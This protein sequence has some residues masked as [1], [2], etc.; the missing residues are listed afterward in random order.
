LDNSI[1]KRVIILPGKYIQG[2]GVLAGIYDYISILGKKPVFIWTKSAR[3]VLSPVILPVLKKNNLDFFEVLFSG[4]CTRQEAARISGEAAINGADTVIGAG[5]G[6]VIDIAKAVAA[7]NNAPCM[8]IPTVP[9]SDA[10]ASSYTVW[11]NEEGEFD[12]SNGWKFNPDIVI[13]DTEILVKAPKRFFIAGIG[14]ALA[15]WY[16]AAAV[17]SSG[18]E[19][20]AG[21]THTLTAVNSAKLCLDILFEYGKAA[22]ESVEKKAVSAAFENVIEAVIFL[23]GIGWENCGVATAHAIAMSI[24]S[25]FKGGHKFLHGECVAFGLLCQLCLEKESK[26]DELK[27][28][29]GFMA[30]MELPLSFNDLGIKDVSFKKIKELARETVLNQESV[31]NHNF[32]VTAKKLA[33]AIF[34][35]NEIGLKRK[36]QQEILNKAQG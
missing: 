26:M 1:K 21:G 28:V 33:D 12:G 4:E 34:Y 17:H 20:P 14:D 32:K 8:I 7:Y 6:K 11:Y 24:Y 36:N 30:E 18:K 5:G 10:S 19:T 13:A 22:K 16:E 2:P 25:V 9:S 35:A 27:R 23:S 31:H 3:A 29:I 15:T